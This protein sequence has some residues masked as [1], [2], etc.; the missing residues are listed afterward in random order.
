MK[1]TGYNYVGMME[2][3]GRKLR[4]AAP[5]LLKKGAT[6]FIRPKKVKGLTY[7]IKKTSDWL[8]GKE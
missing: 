5:I 1:G 8:R 6:S 4:S 2:Q 3:E 7:D